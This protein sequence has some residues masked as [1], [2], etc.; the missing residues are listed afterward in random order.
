MK[1]KKKKKLKKYREKVRGKDSN[2]EMSPTSGCVYAH[3][4]ESPTGNVISGPNT[5]RESGKLQLPVAHAITRGNL[6]GIT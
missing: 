1:I 3:P 6:F 4:R 5:I 2:R